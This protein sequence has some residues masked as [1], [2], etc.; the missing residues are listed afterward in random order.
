MSL[1]TVNNNQ[2]YSKFKVGYSTDILGEVATLVITITTTEQEYKDNSPKIVTSEIPLTSALSTIDN[3]DE[4]VI[5]VEE[6]PEIIDGLYCFTVYIRDEN[7]S[8]IDTITAKY[9]IMYNAEVT[10]GLDSVNLAQSLDI[11]NPNYLQKAL[12]TLYQEELLVGIQRGNAVGLIPETLRILEYIKY[13]L[14][15]N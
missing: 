7:D 2:D 10:I 6:L 8:I 1:L 15:N 4:I 11:G 12:E 3:P 9:M 5:P 13:I 14:K